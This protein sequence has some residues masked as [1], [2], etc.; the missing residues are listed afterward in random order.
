MKILFACNFFAPHI[1]GAEIAAE[2]LALEMARRRHGVAV[3]SGRR[4]DANTPH[5]YLDIEQGEGFPVFRMLRFVLV[6]FKVG[7]SVLK[8]THEPC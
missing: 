8:G 5:G 1:V 3:L 2:R 6:Q 4:P 7:S